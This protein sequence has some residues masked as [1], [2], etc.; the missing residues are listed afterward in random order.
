MTKKHLLILLAIFSVL[1]QISCKKQE[2]PNIVLIYTDDQGYGDVS[3]LNPNACFETPNID[4]IGNEGVI[5]TDGHSSDAVCTPSRYSMLT[6]RYSWRTHLKKG[7]L[8]AD[9]DCL[10][11]KGR[12]TIASL[13]K[14]EGYTTAMVG[15]WHL[16]MQFPG[17]KGNRNW[18][19]AITDGP[20]DKGF[21]YFWGIAASMN[22][23]MLCYI[24]NDRVV[25]IPSMWTR[26]KH[27]TEPYRDYRMCPPY[28][29]VRKEVSDLEVAPSF[30]DEDVLSNFARKAVEFIDDHNVEVRNGRPFFLYLALTSPHLPHSVH[31]DFQGSSNCGKYG[32]FM[33]ETDYRVGQV[34]EALDRNGLAE[35]TMLIF[36]SDNGPETNYHYQMEEF[37]HDCNYIFKGGKRDIYEGGHRVPFLIRWPRVTEGG[38]KIDSPVCQVDLLAS[39]A[40]LLG[41][42][43]PDA[44]GEDSYSLMQ[45]LVDNETK[46]LDRGPLIHHSANG[47]FAIR[48]DNWKLNMLRGSGGSLK[49]VFLEPQQGEPP[50]ELYNLEDDPGETTNLYTQYPEKAEELR[51]RITSI[52]KNGRTTEGSPQKYVKTDW[53]QINWMEIE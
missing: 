21:D 43:L 31:P 11:E 3:A 16:N 45:A 13:L 8:G 44:A 53:P 42:S 29:S 19:K 6:G 2:L 7:V 36:T 1:G 52:I 15:K 17:T 49:P 28:D 51:K 23:G 37:G 20:N 50:F 5:F 38:R 18:N 46:T 30:N 47:Y 40:D 4:R 27:I 9:G 35:N 41:V 32:D 39:F 22:F 33:K 34:L 25:E 10:I 48:E 12:M 26:K 24:E 14:K